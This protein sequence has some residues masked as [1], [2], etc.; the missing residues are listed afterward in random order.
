[1]TTMATETRNAVESSVKLA[2]SDKCVGWEEAASSGRL[3][4]PR[5][6]TPSSEVAEQRV[7]RGSRARS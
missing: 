5:W 1:M 6:D 3:P 7:R 4:F 2:K